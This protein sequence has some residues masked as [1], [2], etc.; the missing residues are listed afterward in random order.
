MRTLIATTMLCAVVALVPAGT[1]AAAES[2]RPKDYVPGE[3][4]VRF[5]DGRERLVELPQGVGVGDA[6]RALRSNP[7]VA[8]A[9]P[10]YLARASFVPNDPGLGATPGDWRRTQWN[11]L[12]CGSLC[13]QSITPLPF[14]A[15]GGVNAIDAWDILRQ[16]GRPGG[17]GTVV[18]VLD[19]G[20]AYV[21]ERPG[22]RKSPDFQTKQFLPGRNFVKEKAKPL[23]R[24]GHGTHVTG[25]IAARTGNNFSLTGLAS[26]AK[27]IP[28]QVLDAQGLGTARDIG[29]G[30]RF[31]VKHG[32][33]VVNMSFEFSA[34]VNS[35]AKIKSVCSAIR[36]A[37]KRRAVVVSAAGNEN[38]EPV[39]LP[40]GAPGVI[41]V[42][43]ITKDGCLASESRT[44]AGLDLVA[45]GGGIPLSLSC[46]KD[47]PLFR[48]SATIIQLTFSGGN[49]RDYGYPGGYEGT[50]MAAAH[51]SGI[52]AMVIASGVLG[53]HPSPV[54]VECQL[55]ATARH[56]STQ[57]GQAYDPRLFGGGLVD[58]A[59][60]VTARASGC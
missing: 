48:R 53:R 49:F 20:V 12:P 55:E 4:L 17:K 39:A 8:Y 45:P 40:A 47:D 21:S 14:E 32:A 9:N 26:R 31:A 19:T 3:L 60:A 22:Y 7:A 15:R 52:A 28:V 29:Q 37:T 50:S 43:R 41:G 59:A 23:D 27:I 46:G 24:D 56:D 42:G 51:V 6:A 18:A 38:G 13:G 2:P 44:G 30:I 1:A 57:L 36:F 5:E 11:F 58:A 10:N 16:R 35:C 34:A 54:A 25:T 33:Q